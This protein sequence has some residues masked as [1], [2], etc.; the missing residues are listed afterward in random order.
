MTVTLSRKDLLD[1]QVSILN[2]GRFANAT[3]RLC[4]INGDDWVMKDFAPKAWI[5]RKTYGRSLLRRE[6][7]AMA[8]LQG[9]P[10]IARDVQRVD[11]EAIAYRHMPGRVLAK[12]PRGEYPPDYFPALE[13]LVRAMHER[14]VVHL[15][16]RYMHNVLVCDDGSPALIDFQTAIHTDKYPNW[17]SRRLEQVDISG[18]YKHWLKRSPETLDEERRDKLE[19]HKKVRKLWILTGYLGRRSRERKRKA[20]LEAKNLST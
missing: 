18:V 9:L 12:C 13:R 4:R 1:H 16:I 19:K 15:D 6:Y 2:V 14:G 3:L 17:L 7:N 10:G 5:I 11:G 8:K 20:K